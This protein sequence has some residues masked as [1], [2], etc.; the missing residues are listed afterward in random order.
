MKTY[1][2]AD[3]DYNW[4]DFT[5]SHFS[6]WLN[7]EYDLNIKLIPQP[8]PPKI[9]GAWL[10]HR[11]QNYL[12]YATDISPFHQAHAILH[13]MGHLLSGHATYEI[14]D[15]DLHD[16]ANGEFELFAFA[17]KRSTADATAEEIEAEM[18]AIQVQERVI[19][20]QEYLSMG[21]PSGE[22]HREFLSAL[23]LI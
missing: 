9:F 11:S 18:F 21:T 10:K 3:F 6:D 4:S 12:F 17:R 15:Q 5:I 23:G 2:I 22:P 8:L 13:E 19:A 7:D 20:H 14:T 16:Y 1:T